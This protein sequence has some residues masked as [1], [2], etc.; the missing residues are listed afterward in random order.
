[1]TPIKLKNYH[2]EVT[3]KLKSLPRPPLK[4]AQMS[5]RYVGGVGHEK[6][7]A[8]EQSRHTFTGVKLPILKAIEQDG[9]SFSKLSINEQAKIWNHIWCNSNSFEE[10]WFALS[11][12][13]KKPIL[14][15]ITDFW[16]LLKGCV[17]HVDNWAHS[18]GLSHIYAHVLETDHKKY[19]P[20]FTRLNK[21]KNPWERRQS[22]VSLYYYTRLRT[23]TLPAHVG[24]KMVKN[25]IGDKHIYVQKGVGWTLREIYQVDQKAQV[26]FVKK[27]VKVIPPTGYYATVE[28]YPLSLK[29]EI[30]S[31]RMKR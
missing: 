28:K 17:K 23:K 20:F 6:R 5:A 21:S 24:L 25:L 22:I 2:K 30:K 7:K 14:K 27:H 3:Q 1:M 11:F 8:D 13:S 18:D 12:F 10:K 29:K 9:F 31:L 16:P 26:E 19:L 15:K 4:V